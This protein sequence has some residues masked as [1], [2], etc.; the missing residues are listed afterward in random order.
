MDLEK[1]DLIVRRSDWT[2]TL[3]CLDGQPFSLQDYPFYKAVYDGSYDGLLL[4]TARQVAKSTTLSN[5]LI[6]EA[7]TK[8]H[9]RS[10]F[11]APSQEQTTKFSQTRVGKTVF[12]SPEIRSRWVSQDLSSRVYQKM[13]TNG[14]EIA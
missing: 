2:Q 11:I 5:F 9:W 4:K 13:F 10:L 12:Y 6:A 14:S 8:P 1:Q 7:C 3:I